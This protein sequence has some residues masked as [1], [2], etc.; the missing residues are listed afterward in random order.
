MV[1]KAVERKKKNILIPTLL[2]AVK[3]ASEHIIKSIN[4]KIERIIIIEK[5]NT[6]WR[7]G[8]GDDAEKN[9]ETADINLMSNPANGRMPNE[10][11]RLEQ[12]IFHSENNGML[13]QIIEIEKNRGIE[14]TKEE[15]KDHLR[16]YLKDIKPIKNKEDQLKTSEKKDIYN[17]LINRI[18]EEIKYRND[19]RI[20]NRN[21]E[22]VTDIISRL[23]INHIIML[24]SIFLLISV[25]KDIERRI[26][27]GEIPNIFEE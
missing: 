3:K 1:K 27:I 8:F 21:P 19:K 23:D 25:R 10:E 15:A 22:D 17:L 14:L 4:F 11:E 5:S 16:E 20:V 12:V 18:Y 24:N 13:D 6:Q 9:F 7:V 26:E 2:E